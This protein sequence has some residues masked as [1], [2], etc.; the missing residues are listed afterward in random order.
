V[1]I[2]LRDILPG[3]APTL[4]HIL[5]A[6]NEHAFRGRVP[7]Q[8]L[9]FSEAEST[10]NWQRA[11]TQGLP[12]GDFMLVAQTPVGEVV[13][14]AWGG[15]FDDA[16]FQGELRQIMVLPTYQGQGIG[17]SLLC[18]VAERLLEQQIHNMRVEVLYVNPNRAFYERMGGVFLEE[19]LYDWDGVMLPRYVYGWEDTHALLA[20]KCR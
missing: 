3:D 8:C 18:R 10:A 15:A 4:A 2:T 14:Y 5:I 19:G 16:T 11:L 20:A 1:E 9:E 6:A 12:E 7:D 17:S 13:G